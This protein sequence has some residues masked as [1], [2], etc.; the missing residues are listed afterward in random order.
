MKNNFKYVFKFSVIGCL[1]SWSFGYLYYMSP[2]GVLLEE[3]GRGGFSIVEKDVQKGSV[4]GTVINDDDSAYDSSYFE[5]RFE[6]MR[7]NQDIVDDYHYLKSRELAIY[8]S[9]VPWAVIGFIIN[10]RKILDSL[11]LFLIPSFFTILDVF[12]LGE[13]VFMFLSYCLV[14]ILR[15]IYVFKSR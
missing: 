6:W 15:K 4:K 5:Q 13:F 9:W 14:F 12:L 11:F 10:R 7:R 2:T 8:L 1:I 3:D